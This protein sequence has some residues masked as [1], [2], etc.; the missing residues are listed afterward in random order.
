MRS[1]AGTIDQHGSKIL[2]REENEHVFRLLGNRCQSLAT[3]VVQLFVTDPPNHSSWRRSDAGILC[4][5]KDNQ[6]RSY[7]FRLYCLTRGQMVWEHEV[8]NSMDYLSPRTWFHSFEG[9]VCIFWNMEYDARMVKNILNEK[10]EAKKQRRLERRSRSSMQP[11]SL[12]GYHPSSGGHVT[13]SLSNLQNG[14]VPVARQQSR[15]TP[16]GKKK[17]KD[18]KRRLTKADIGLPKDFRHV[19]HVGWDPN[20]GFDLENIEDPQ[21]KVFFEKVRVSNK[22]LDRI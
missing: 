18:S 3:A 2:S 6:R 20:K 7:F 4:L 19:S 15:V 22:M 9:E 11:R 14:S 5:V 12:L 8:Y 13:G 1:E 21:L 16:S 10:F 17:D